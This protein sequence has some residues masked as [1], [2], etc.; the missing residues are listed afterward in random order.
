VRRANRLAAAGETRCVIAAHPGTQYSYQTALGLDEAGLLRS[1]VTGFYY[2][3]HGCAARSLSILPGRVRRPFERELMR[4]HQPGL[5]A[6]RV[7]TLPALE[8]AF[9]TAGR[10]RGL[11][12]AAR[13]IM[14]LRNRRFEHAVAAII[15]R[16]RPAAVVCPDSCALAP[17]RAAQE[18][19]ARCVL[20]QSIA[21]QRTGLRILR[22]EAER[23]PEFADTLQLDQIEA[24]ARNSECEPE[25]A[26]RIL[27]GSDFV[28]STLIDNGVDPSKITV[29]PFGADTDRFRPA[30]NPPRQ[31][32]RLLFVGYVSQRKGIK[33]LLEAV[34]RLDR[35]DLELVVVGDPVG[36]TSGLM[37]YRGLFT[38][39]TGVAHAD[40]H[41]WYQSADLFV[42]PS[43][44][45][46]SARVTYEALASGLPVI[47]TAN[48]G[49]V[50][51]D[52]IDGFIVPIRDV[53]ALAGK[54]AA[55]ADDR[56]LREQMG[57]NARAR[58]EQFTWARYRRSIAAVV[59]G[60]LSLGRDAPA[61][62]HAASH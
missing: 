28:R 53:D 18:V 22:E 32:V 8:L 40:V 16:E 29:V 33:Y 14:R 49:S 25:A 4:R 42:L 2:D 27:A 20:D 48:S 3:R 60:E 56:T 7:R 23:C 26:D 15:R 30:P 34:K 11:A 55:L 9:V 21:D 12:G 37:R 54:I 19:G 35:R 24:F 61:C 39:V 47:T 58:A 36:G 50:V 45:E 57:R 10:V 17:F 31:P 46:G 6:A 59:R 5:N 38:H 52:G 1:F 51:R 41:R 62:A 13:A 44:F 43:L